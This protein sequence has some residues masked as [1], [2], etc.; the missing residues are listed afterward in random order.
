[1][2][3]RYNKIIRKS[4]KKKKNERRQ[5]RERNKIREAGRKRLRKEEQ[6]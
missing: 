1:M 5:R 6:I 3:D 4:E 2:Q